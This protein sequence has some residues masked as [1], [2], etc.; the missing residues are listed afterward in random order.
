MIQFLSY[1][2]QYAMKDKIICVYF[3]SEGNNSCDVQRKINNFVNKYT[4]SGIFN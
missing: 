2:M 4:A 3:N 1:L